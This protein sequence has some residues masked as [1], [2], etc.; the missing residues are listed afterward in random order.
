MSES[1][2][3]WA[4]VGTSG[5]VDGRFAP[6]VRAAGQRVVGAFGS[7]PAGSARFADKHG[8]TAYESLAEMLADDAVD[9]VWVASPTAAHPE[10][11]RAVAA[12]GKALLVE[13]PLAVDVPSAGSLVRELVPATP[14]AGVGFQHRFNAGVRALA[15]ALA[16]GQAGTLSSVALHHCVAGPARPTEWRTDPALSGGWS[17]TDLGA[18]LLDTARFLLGDLEFV[19]ARLSSP[20]RS[21]AVDDLSCLMLT[22][23]PATVIVRASTGTPGPPSYI[24]V[25]GTEGWLRLTGFWTGGGTLVDSDGK[26]TEIP[27]EDPYVAQVAAFSAAVRGEPWP[28]ASLED[29]ARIVEL[30]SAARDF[31]G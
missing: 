24:E 19:A 10:H 21:L 16:T 30:T 12:S 18:H 5:W 3:G 13:K 7:S 26:V 17:I 25:S 22:R 1:S 20:G 15:D 11:A 2:V 9:A 27:A 31:R 23:G 8:G 6:S 14:V 28:G 29:G 4:F